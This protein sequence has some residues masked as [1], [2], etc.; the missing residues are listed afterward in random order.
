MKKQLFSGLV[1][2]EN[3]RPAETAYVGDEPCYVVDDAGFRRHIPS[4]QVD[5]QVLS[6]MQELIKGSE[7]LVSEQAAKMLGQ[8]DLF[9]VAAI[10]TQLKN[11]D[12]QFDNMLQVGLPEDA[13]A[14]LGMLGF[15]IIINVHGDV[16]SVEQPGAASDDG[17]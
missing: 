11:M 1:F 17:E 3:N 12:K 9:S 13:R 7:N 2:D 5:R 14:Y 10:A 16:V 8:D 15:K 6:Q 4:E